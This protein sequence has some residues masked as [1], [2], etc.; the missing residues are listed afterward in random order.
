[1][2]I[3]ELSTQYEVDIEFGNYDESGYLSPGGYQSI[4]NSLADKHLINYDMDFVKIFEHGISWVLLSISLDIINPIHS[5][6][7]KIIGKTWFSGR[8]GIYFRRELQLQTLEGEPL[9]NCAT[10]STLLNLQT[11]GIYKNR[12]LPFELM[13]PTPNLIIEAKPSFKEKLEYDKGQ[14]R[15]VRRSYIDGLGHVNNGRYG[16]F[17]FDALSEELKMEHLRRMEIYFMSEMRLGQN[18]STNT[19]INEAGSTV[20]QGYNNSSE[21]PSFYGVFNFKQA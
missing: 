16:D 8:K 19:A 4:V 17:C 18:F 3:D 7:K 5:K 15:T 13:E 9:F 1:M 6:H 14:A 11:R 2:I 21:K 12:E 10:Y 20:V